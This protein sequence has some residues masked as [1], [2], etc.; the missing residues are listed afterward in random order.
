[1]NLNDKQLFVARAPAASA[2]TVTAYVPVGPTAFRF[3][4][5]QWMYETAEVNVDNT[6]DF[7][8]AYTTDGTNFTTLHS[9]ANAVGLLDTAA[10][11]TT[12][13]NKGDAVAGGGA[14][15]AVTPTAAEVPA[16]AVLRFTL[17]TAGTGTV[18]A[19]QLQAYGKQH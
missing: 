14:A 9:N 16:N 7:A 2:G 19:V 11:L 15:V 3:E 6:F 5:F 18:P 17:V 12:Q 4:G 1:M 13:Q 8:I 10:V